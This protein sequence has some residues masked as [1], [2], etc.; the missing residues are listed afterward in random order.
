MKIALLGNMNNNH[1]SLMRYLRDMGY[2][3]YLLLYSTDGTEGNSHFIPENDT[4][5]FEKWEQYIIQTPI[6]NGSFKGLL[7][8]FWSYRSYKKYVEGYDLIIGNGFAPALSYIFNLPLDL[9]LPYSYGVEFTRS[10]GKAPSFTDKIQFYFQKRGL[11]K[12]VINIGTI[13]FSDDNVSILYNLG[14][15]QK[16]HKLSIPMV[17]HEEN[18]SL[19]ENKNIATII[20]KIK[21]YKIKLFSHVS[22]VKYE[23][24]NN[25]KRNDILIEGF[26]KYMELSSNKNAVLIL[27]DYG[28]NVVAS[29][30]LIQNLNIDQNVM[31]L[32]KMSRKEIMNLLQHIDVGGGELGGAYWGGTGWEFLAIGIPFFQNTNMTIEEFKEK[33][34]TPMPD[35]FNVSSSEEIGNILYNIEAGMI[36]LKSKSENLKDWFHTFN[37]KAEV[38][39]IV[40]LLIQK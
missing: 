13:D 39:R 30:N 2:D 26:A 20:E 22:H 35:I 3:S 32:P 4:W 18:Y 7:D 27:L 37:G 9:F 5:N 28:D 17:Y 16:L 12:S 29:K 34:G 36:D 14:L 24:G 15:K 1:F 40:S 25:I 19:H 6:P 10:Y 33:T 8:I 23:L 11:I 38:E 31:W 21:T